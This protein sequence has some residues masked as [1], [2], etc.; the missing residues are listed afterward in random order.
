M[1]ELGFVIACRKFF[2]QQKDQ[3]LGE[4]QAEVKKL[5]EQD[6]K[7]LTPGLEAALGCKIRA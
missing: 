3:S 7:D 2:G 4:F 5:T 6:R 1:E